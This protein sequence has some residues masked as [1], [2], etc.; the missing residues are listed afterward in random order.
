MK[1]GRDVQAMPTTPQ[2]LLASNWASKCHDEEQVSLADG[3]RQSGLE[4]G[5]Q[6][7]RTMRSR[8]SD[9]TDS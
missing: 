6:R 3:R 2:M 8:M 4:A 1:E 9:M 5:R 7:S